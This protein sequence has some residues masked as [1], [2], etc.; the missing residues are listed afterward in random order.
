MR[1]SPTSCQNHQA[2]SP[3]RCKGCERM[4]GEVPAVGQIKSSVARF[5]KRNKT[6]GKEMSGK[7]PVRVCAACKETKPI[8]GRGLCPSCYHK[9]RKA[10]A[11][12]KP[13]KDQTKT[14]RIEQ[15]VPKF[16]QP[17]VT[18]MDWFFDGDD[19]LREKILA[20]AKKERRDVRQQILFYLDQI[21]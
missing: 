18:D 12:A 9:A 21:I 6:K 5:S 7:K 20:A 8:L 15:I 16:C 13:I 17:V 10:E 14:E 3:E 19:E 2:A 4:I 11:C 1:L